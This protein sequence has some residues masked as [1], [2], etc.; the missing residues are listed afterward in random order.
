M[1]NRHREGPIFTSLACAMFKWERRFAVEL[2]PPLAVAQP[3][4]DLRF[5]DDFYDE[6]AEC[7]RALQVAPSAIRASN[8]PTSEVYDILNHNI[9]SLLCQ[10]YRIV[11]WRFQPEQLS[12][13]GLLETGASFGSYKKQLDRL[14]LLARRQAFEA[15]QRAMKSLR[16]MLSDE[17][18]ILSALFVPGFGVEHEA[19][20]LWTSLL[21]SIEVD[22]NGG[23]YGYTIDA[24]K[25]D[26]ATLR[27]VVA[28]VSWSNVSVS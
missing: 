10:V 28:I 4:L 25:T 9:D 5:F 15:S 11:Q 8:E 24:K 3:C 22:E 26:L 18:R 1:S 23:S 19:I 20:P 13:A 12:R 6:Y 27:E 17:H 16:E 2:S 7:R 21:L 14:L